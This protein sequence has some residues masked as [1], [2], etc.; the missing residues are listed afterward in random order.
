MTVGIIFIGYALDSNVNRFL[1]VNSETSEIY[2]TITEVRDV[3]FED[4]FPFKSRIPS[5]PSYIPSISDIPSSSSAPIIDSK[6]RRS[7]KIKIL[8]SFGE[9]FS[10]Y[11]VEGD[12]SSFREAMNSFESPF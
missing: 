5:D 6:P 4:I 1:V 2:N 3:Y 11:F 8:I 12:P 7:K 9:N 10:T